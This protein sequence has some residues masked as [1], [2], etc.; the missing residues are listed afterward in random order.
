[1]ATGLLVLGN[2]LFDPKL[3]KHPSASRIDQVFMREDIELCTYFKFHQLK[4]FF[5]LAAMRTYASELRESG[6]SVTYQELSKSNKKYEEH[7]IEWLKKHSIRKLFFYEI[8]DK[9]FNQRILEALKQAS[10]QIEVEIEILPSPM[11]LTS[12]ER[13]KS[14]LAK[15]KRPFM[16][17][18]YE[19]QRQQLGILMEAGGQPTGGRWSF[20][21][22]NRKHLPKTIQP[23]EPD[24]KTLSKPLR[25]SPLAQRVSQT[26]KTFF[27]DHPG[28]PSELW[29][30]VDRKSAHLWLKDFIHH[31]LKEF[32]PYED[33]LTDRSDFVFHSALTPFLNTGLL[34]PQEVITA[35]LS[36]AK[37]QKI[38]LASVE[39]F[40][41]QVIGWREFIRG[42]YQNFSEVQETRN[43]WNHN[44]K[45]SSS[46]YEANTGIEPLDDVLKK[47]N[48]L[49][50]A[51][52]IERLMVVGNLML[53][54]E[55]H[56]QEA[57]RWFMEMFIDSS[58]W[59]MGPNVY[60]MG[61]FSDGGVFA[62]KP[63]ICGSN[64]YRKMGG[65]KAGPWCDT[66]DGLY[67]SF[68]E[69]HTA[70]FQ[71]NPRLSM[72]ASTVKKMDPEKKKRIYQAADELRKRLTR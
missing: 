11:F 13:F 46:W 48:R 51:H 14:Y 52:H 63:Y 59:V 40:V 60:G 37:R 33:A 62:T 49:G 66:V 53:L 54:L 67:W 12:R 72:M 9:F 38:E 15:N 71:K 1:M 28:D 24:W 2:Q 50:Y 26:C 21:E 43:F 44:R 31:R 17:T 8:E 4:I 3:L 32:G 57:H 23:P 39:G 16:R 19:S 68:V 45:L 7:L 41:R 56:P 61:I 29:F 69:K 18:F 58:D 65:Y 20:D 35:I 55:I 36:E 70:F 64:Y 47:V 42:I 5:F 25:D 34:T 6:F 22:E 27:A 10:T 30:P